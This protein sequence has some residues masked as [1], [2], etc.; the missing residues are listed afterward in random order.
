M[1]RP[2]RLL[3]IVAMT[4]SVVACSTTK[5]TTSL[6]Q[7]PSTRTAATV[8]TPRIKQEE[9]MTKDESKKRHKEEAKPASTPT[10]APESKAVVVKSESVKLIES[11]GSNH[12]AGMYHVIVGS[13][14]SL[15]NAKA[16]SNNAIKQGFLP[17]I[18]ENNEGMYRVAVF[19][20][21]EASARAKVAEIREHFKE[22]VGIWL[23]LEK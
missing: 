23:L 2:I 3:S 6:K 11:E 4:L 16:A 10:E 8:K 21:D 14:K 5:G 22:Y 18:M 17:S 7:T 12:A 1:T 15:E 20:G 19:S 13:F 9:D